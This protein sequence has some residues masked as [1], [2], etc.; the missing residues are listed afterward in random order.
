MGMYDSING[1]Q[2]KCFPWV[3]YVPSTDIPPTDPIWFHGGS[4]NSF[5]SG[6]SVPFQEFHY[7]YTPNFMILDDH[8]TEEEFLFVL[9]IIQEGKVQM[10]LFGS[11]DLKLRDENENQ[12]SVEEINQLFERNQM[13]ID[14]Y[15]NCLNVHSIEDVKNCVT[16]KQST[17]EKVRELSKGSHGYFKKYAQVMHGVGLL[18][19]A[20]EEF[21]ERKKKSDEYHKKYQEEKEREQ[22][23]ID[24]AWDQFSQQ[25]IQ[26]YPYEKE[27]ELGSWISAY[28][29]HTSLYEKSKEEKWKKELEQLSHDFQNAF[30]N[31]SSQDIENY[32]EWQKGLSQEKKQKV[33]EVLNLLTKK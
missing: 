3:S 19:T 28:V 4:L 29:F 5:Q 16:E 20:S 6:N 2:V 9:H 26:E 23:F 7:N 15:G 32:L 33:L 22:P 31:L 1:E 24:Q 14:Y 27:K 10:S 17:I 21:K 8:P 13:V 25:W 11:S 12:K 18:D 30:P